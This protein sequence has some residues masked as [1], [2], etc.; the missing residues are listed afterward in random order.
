[1][2][3]TDVASFHPLFLKERV[4]ASVRLLI[5]ALMDLCGTQVVLQLLIRSDKPACCLMGVLFHSGGG[6]RTQG[7]LV[8]FPDL[9]NSRVGLRPCAISIT[10]S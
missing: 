7:E 2:Q 6:K 9:H 8:P 3:L 1:V 5:T 10:L 4:I